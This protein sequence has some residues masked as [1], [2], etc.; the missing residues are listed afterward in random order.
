[1]TGP[2][3]RYCFLP[4]VPAE[5]IEGALLLAVLATEALHGETRV[6]LDA[7]HVCDPTHRA[8]VIG[9]GTAVGIDLN[10]LF[11]SF[12]SRQFGAD[13]FRVERVEGDAPRG[14]ARRRAP[15]AA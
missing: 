15:A 11:V 10:K 14:S 2:R 9:A 6:R 7:E 8:C 12:A 4:H 5:E 1:M 13:A 3:Y